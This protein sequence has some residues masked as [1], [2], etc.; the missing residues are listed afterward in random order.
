M[1]NRVMFLNIYR[2][3]EFDASFQQYIDSRFQGSPEVVVRSFDESLRDS[4]PRYLHQVGL[5]RY[6]SLTLPDTLHKIVECEAEGFDAAVIGCYCDPALVEARETVSN[7]VVTAPAE[8]SMLLAMALGRKFSTLVTTRTYVPPMAQTVVNYGFGERL[9][10]LRTIDVNIQDLQR[11]REA[12]LSSLERAA[13]CAIDEDHADVI[14]LGCTDF[15]GLHEEL[16]E[17][18]GRPVIDCVLASV[19]FADYLADVKRRLG[20]TYVKVAA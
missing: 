4:E 12:T 3:R 18:L 17:A 14:I 8:A 13:R 1:P 19:A 5:H 16:Q 11:D 10:S 7:L 2:G 15:F 20:Y 9:A 6:E